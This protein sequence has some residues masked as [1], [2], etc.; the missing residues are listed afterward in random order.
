[1]EP[2]L[3]LIQSPL[4]SGPITALALTALYS[5]VLNILPLYLPKISTPL[6]F[7]STEAPTPLQAALSA[8]TASLA[9]CRFPSSSPAQDELVLL[10]LL[11][12]IE[13][14]VTSPMENELTDEGVC[15]MLEVGLGMGGRARLG[16]TCILL[17]Q[18]PR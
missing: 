8:I 4:T 12:M 18:H 16:G 11:K 1:M 2:F 14:L 6:I 17:A 5:F 9:H 15:E 7:D 3:A 10:R 13:T